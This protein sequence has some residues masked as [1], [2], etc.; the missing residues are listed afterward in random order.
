L[1]LDVSDGRDARRGRTSTSS[2]A[3]RIL[4]QVCARD[5]SWMWQMGETRAVAE[6]LTSS[7]AVRIFRN[8]STRDRSWMWQMGE[9]R[10]RRP[11]AR[12]YQKRARR[13]PSAPSCRGSAETTT[14][15]AYPKKKLRKKKNRS[16]LRV[17]F[18]FFSVCPSMSDFRGCLPPFISLSLFLSLSLFFFLF[19]FYKK[20]RE[21][22]RERKGYKGG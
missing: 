8:V 21:R 7:P 5:R 17:R 20:K 9:T 19:T 14:P 1:K 4:G 12:T 3:V 6:W 10:S 2:P 18:F 16:H 13:A 11:C 22:E 15:G